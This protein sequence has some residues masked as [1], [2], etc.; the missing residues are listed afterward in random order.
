[1]NVR[2][3][4]H[5]SNALGF[6]ALGVFAVV[7]L[8]LNG[9]NLG[10]EARQAAIGGASGT[11]T[12]MKII[13]WAQ[14]KLGTPYYIPGNRNHEHCMP[15][16]P[17]NP[18]DPTP[19]PDP[20]NVTDLTY[21]CDCSGLTSSAY[22]FGAGLVI[23][24][25]ANEQ[26]QLGQHNQ[27]L[28]LPI[29]QVQPGDL[30]FPETEFNFG[31]PGHVGMYVGEIPG[32][33]KQV[34]IQAPHTGDF[35]KYTTLK[36]WGPHKTAIRP[37]VLIKA[38]EKDMQN[39]LGGLG[40]VSGGFSGL[41]TVS[42]R[43][44]GLPA[45]ATSTAACTLA[46][47]QALKNS[48]R[49]S[50]LFKQVQA[51]CM[52]LAMQYANEFKLPQIYFIRQIKFESDFDPNALGPTVN[53][54]NAQGIAQF[55]SYL[56]HDFNHWDPDRSLYEAA[57]ELMGHW[58]SHLKQGDGYVEAYM[59]ILVDYN[60]G[61]FCRDYQL[62]SG[63]PSCTWYNNLNRETAGYIK[64]IMGIDQSQISKYIDTTAKRYCY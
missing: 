63:K 19:L 52:L 37:N 53:G 11:A 48:A 54:G 12:V 38:I 10:A 31:S 39:G 9:I 22:Y 41:P 15:N 21:R 46:N 8:L 18:A 6:K 58:Y 24:Q 34:V 26:Y 13:A 50:A 35:V 3:L 62:R 44:L 16:N 32:I 42:T 36:N 55:M 1:V 23:P 43:D 33:G 49:G 25:L 17:K 60:C 45:P 30:V 61:P 64:N 4:Q 57:K 51:A 27:G 29:D 40:N 20:K 5:V 7:L 59:K 47:G 2:A 56:R 14:S 28:E